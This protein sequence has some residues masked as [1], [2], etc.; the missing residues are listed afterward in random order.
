M[1]WDSRLSRLFNWGNYPELSE[2]N[3]KVVTIRQEVPRSTNQE[4]PEFEIETRD[5]KVFVVGL[6]CL[7]DFKIRRIS[8]IVFDM[9]A[10]ADAV[11]RKKEKED[12]DF[13]V[14]SRD[15]CFEITEWAE[16]FENSYDSYHD[17]LT[18]VEEFAYAKLAE[19]FKE[20]Q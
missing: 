1:M 13:E 5:K 3:G 18:D 11:I 12:P 2:Y 16:E 10:C 19:Y 8:E 20:D 14:D 6:S 17:Y 15:L 7:P 9:T 4:E